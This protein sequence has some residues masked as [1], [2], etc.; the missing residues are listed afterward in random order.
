MMRIPTILIQSQEGKRTKDHQDLDRLKPDETGL[1]DP[2]PA[3]TLVAV[4]ESED[5]PDPELRGEMLV[6]VLPSLSL[7]LPFVVLL[8]DNN[9]D[10]LDG[11]LVGA[12]TLLGLAPGTTACDR[13]PPENLR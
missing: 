11:V 4:V 6:S 1:S 2:L 12:F 3:L 13:L 9:D 5:D 7:E 8:T 10:L